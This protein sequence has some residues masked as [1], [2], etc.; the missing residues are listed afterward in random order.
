M[1]QLAQAIEDKDYIVLKQ[2]GSKMTVID[3]GIQMQGLGK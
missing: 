1:S 3:M 2:K